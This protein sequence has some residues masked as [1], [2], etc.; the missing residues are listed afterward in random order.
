N[1]ADEEM[2]HA[3]KILDYINERNGRVLLLP[4]DQP[5][6]DWESPLDVFQSALKH[7][8]HVTQ[9]IND[10]V[11][12]S[13]QENDQASFS[14]LQWFVDEQVEEEALV[15][16]AVQDLKLVGD[17]GPGLFLLDRELGAAQPE[18]EA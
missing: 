2:V 10:L 13:S 16:A 6:I 14:F 9:L 5:Q 11:L 1:H 8:Q 4:L 18:D 15:D 12:L 17:Y 3:M 7:E